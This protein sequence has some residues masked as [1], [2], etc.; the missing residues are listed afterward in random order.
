MDHANSSIFENPD[1][2]IIQMKTIF[3]RSNFRKF[4]QLTFIGNP[5]SYPNRASDLNHPKSVLVKVV[6]VATPRSQAPARG[7]GEGINSLRHVSS[8]P[9]LPVSR[10]AGSVSHRG[11]A[12]FGLPGQ[13]PVSF[14][15]L[16]GLSGLISIAT[17]PT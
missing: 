12:N 4:R 17:P 11:T 7:R 15:P 16:I 10:A 14:S 9:A 2:R 5:P 6:L 8:G 1:F 13:P 3:T